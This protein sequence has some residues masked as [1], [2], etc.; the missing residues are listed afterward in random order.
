MCTLFSPRLRN[1][2]KFAW[3]ELPVTLQATMCFLLLLV[4]H[5][6]YNGHM[7][8]SPSLYSRFD[9][10]IDGA[11]CWLPRKRR[12]TIVLC[13]YRSRRPSFRPG[14]VAAHQLIYFSS[15]H[16]PRAYRYANVFSR[17]IQVTHWF[18]FYCPNPDPIT[19]TYNLGLYDCAVGGL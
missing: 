14:D 18:F 16:A 2:K 6:R 1:T 4:A 10:S 3:L 13:T 11:S 12:G 15:L 17:T 5:S 19:F 7:S 8:L 9:L